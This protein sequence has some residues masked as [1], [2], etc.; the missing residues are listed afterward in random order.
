MTEAF[1]SRMQVEPLNR[2][3]WRT[4]VELANAIFEDL[5]ILHHRHGATAALACSPRY[6]SKHLHRGMRIQQHTSTKPRAQQVAARAERTVPVEA[7]PHQGGQGSNPQG[8]HGKVAG[9]SSLPSR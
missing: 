8:V 5:E 4:R 6:S 3:R 1:W 9:E 7:S 2:R